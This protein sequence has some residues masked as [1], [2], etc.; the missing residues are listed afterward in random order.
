MTVNNGPP[1]PA[2]GAPFPRLSLRR[3][4]PLLV[5]VVVSVGV[6]VFGWHRQLSFEEVA[7]HH[8]ALGAFIA[9]HELQAV[10]AYI[11]LY[12]T[13]AALSIP[14]GFYLTVIGGIL[15]GTVLGGAAALVGA[16]PGAICIFLI[17]RSAIGEYLVRRAGP[18]A[19]GGGRRV[20]LPVVRA[21]SF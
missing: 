10:A 7:R 2:D 5:L 13:A 9:R 15:F 1:S 3:L 21:L 12:V 11:A 6:I 20:F 19:G 8:E 14:V 4:A 17:A 18:F 16:T